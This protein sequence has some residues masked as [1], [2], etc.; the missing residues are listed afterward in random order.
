MDEEDQQFITQDVENGISIVE[1][2]NVA[3]ETQRDTSG[4]V[5]CKTAENVPNFKWR[6]KCIFRVHFV[7]VIMNLAV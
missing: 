6:K 5:P 3:R 7:I 1:I 2:E 4:T